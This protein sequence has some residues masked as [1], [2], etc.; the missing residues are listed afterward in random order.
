MSK[1]ILFLLILALALTALLFKRKIHRPPGPVPHVDPES[2]TI[3]D[4]LQQ[5][6]PAA[7]E[8]LRPH[9]DAARVQ[10][11]PAE[12]VLVGLKDD[13]LLELWARNG[14]GER[15]SRIRRYPILGTSGR[16]GPKLREGDRQIP[17]GIYA[18]EALNPNSAFHLSLRLNYPN[19]LDLKHAVEDGRDP[20]GSDIMIHGA[21]RSIGCLAMGDPVAEE[22]FVL[23]ADTGLRNIKVILAPVDLRTTDAPKLS[24]NQPAWIDELYATIRRE[25]EPL[26]LNTE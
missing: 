24:D 12:I 3:T 13:K 16:L 7:R 5:Y 20:P 25:L 9:F 15:F 19:A 23:A 8:R 4:R 10:Y 6:G 18:V 22:L 14:V 17:E 11:P 26:M 21:D 1:R 2:A